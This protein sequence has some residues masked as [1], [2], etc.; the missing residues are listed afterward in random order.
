[1]TVRYRRGRNL[2]AHLLAAALLACGPAVADEPTARRS[3]VALLGAKNYEVACVTQIRDG[4]LI[5]L[6]L[7]TVSGVV[8][9]DFESHPI[10]VVDSLG[11]ARKLQEVPLPSMSDSVPTEKSRDAGSQGPEDTSRYIVHCSYPL[12]G[13]VVIDVVAESSAVEDATVR[14]FT[15]EVGGNRSVAVDVLR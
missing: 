9:H 1:M 4:H 11:T 8:Y 2:A 10:A 13:G 12:R 6:K 7:R 5:A 3:A 14:R 15:L